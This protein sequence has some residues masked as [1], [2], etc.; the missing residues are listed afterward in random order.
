MCQQGNEII[1]KD[2]RA[3]PQ[4][5]LVYSTNCPHFS[6]LSPYTDELQADVGAR[7]NSQAL[8]VSE[9]WWSGVGIVDAGLGNGLEAVLASQSKIQR[10]PILNGRTYVGGSEDLQGTSLSKEAVSV[11]GVGD[12][13][14][15][16]ESHC[17]HTG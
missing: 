1:T 9:L 13:S 12:H 4:V 17:Q 16:L 7:L 11:D 3:V 2:K 5:V 15:N 14:I 10:T 8:V 6:H